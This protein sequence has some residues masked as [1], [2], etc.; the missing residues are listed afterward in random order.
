VAVTPAAEATV[1]LLY[2]QWEYLTVP[3]TCAADVATSGVVCYIFT[4]NDNTSIA[5]FMAAKGQ[6]GW[7]LGGVV[8]T[9]GGDPN[10]TFVFKRPLRTP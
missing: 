2:D 5:N 1:Q 8:S 9:P 10:T 3:A 7:E 4:D 6:Q